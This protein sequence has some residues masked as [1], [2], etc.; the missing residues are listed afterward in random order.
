M[1]VAVRVPNGPAPGRRFGPCDRITIRGVQYRC[2]ENLDE[3]H[4]FKRVDD[5]RMV[6]GFSH[7]DIEAARKR[8]GYRYDKDWFTEVRA[9]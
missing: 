5:A 1:N 3:G 9:K 7:A 4:V 2:I 6:E 8:P